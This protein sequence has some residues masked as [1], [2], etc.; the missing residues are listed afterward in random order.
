[1]K[2]VGHEQEIK[3]WGADDGLDQI[4]QQLSSSRMLK[5]NTEA[6]KKK[7]QI[8]VSKIPP[9]R[10]ELVDNEGT[11]ENLYERGDRMINTES[12]KVGVNSPSVSLPSLS[13][14][15][16][17]KLPSGFLKSPA[18]AFNGSNL[19]TQIS[20]PKMRDMVTYTEDELLKQVLTGKIIE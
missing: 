12:T 18:N 15:T 8:I 19:Y 2:R 7:K 9:V 13:S 4:Q 20:S 3:G 6:F 11:P 1:M 14:P 10:S 17:G 5:Q 16:S